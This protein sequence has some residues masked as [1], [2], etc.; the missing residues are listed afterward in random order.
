ME[1]FNDRPTSCKRCSRCGQWK[2]LSEYNMQSAESKFKRQ[3]YCRQC[4][5]E[6]AK[7]NY[8]PC[9]RSISEVAQKSQENREA[10]NT[11]Y[12]RYKEYKLTLADYATRFGN[13]GLEERMSFEFSLGL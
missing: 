8:S 3:P 12:R 10:Y 2:P 4:Q 5:H 9:G 11:L 13:E 7:E 1:L 6:Y